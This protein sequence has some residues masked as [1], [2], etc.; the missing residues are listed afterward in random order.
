MQNRPA[1]NDSV[2]KDVPRANPPGSDER[3]LIYIPIIHTQADMGALSRSIE[4][5]KIK[6]LGKKGW[7]RNMNLVSRLWAR[8]EQLIE[9]QVLTY[10]QVRVY[11]DGLPVCGRELEIVTELANAG[12]RNHRLLLH[13]RDKG[14]TIMGTESSELLVE[15]YE[16]VKED[17]GSGGAG[18]GQRG[19]ARRKALR[20][21]LLQR[22]DQYIARRINETLRA[23]ETG[24]LFL[25]MLHS[26]RPWLD[27][28]VRVIYPL[29]PAV[30]HG[31][32]RP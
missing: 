26:I 28:D 24:L 10:S 5:L 6:R 22:R 19:G 18:S 16:F 8:I 17:F 29:W 1:G 25:G 9:K 30:N 31:E 20:D 11:Q 7:E 12:S 32:E 15:E 2:R 4:R 21:S 3:T 13:L 14:A 23:G 27:K